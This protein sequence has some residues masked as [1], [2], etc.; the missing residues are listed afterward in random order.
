MPRFIGIPLS[1]NGSSSRD[2]SDPTRIV[3]LSLSMSEDQ[4][5]DAY[6]RVSANCGD[7]FPPRWFETGTK[8]AVT[9]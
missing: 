1:D 9:Y 4:P 6:E 2:G 8:R 5:V 7:T 3:F